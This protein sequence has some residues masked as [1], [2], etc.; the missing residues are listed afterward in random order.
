MSIKAD[1]DVQ[2]RSEDMAII[3][4]VVA[5]YYDTFARDSA[6]AAN[7][8]GVPA[9][10]VLPNEVRSLSTRS[11]IERFLAE[12]LGSLKTLGYSRTRMIDCRI[13]ILNSTTVAYGTVAVRTTADGTELHRAAFTYLLHNGSAGWKIHELIATDLDKLVSSD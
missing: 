6:A 9:L 11:E 13:K 5:A 7:F 10:V 3:H 1:D 8:Y 4:D 12:G 2:N